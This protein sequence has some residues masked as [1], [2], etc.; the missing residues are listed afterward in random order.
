MAGQYDEAL[1]GAARRAAELRSP[2]ASYHVGVTLLLLGDDA[3]TERYLTEKAERSPNFTRLPLGL[4]LLELRRGQPRAAVER[5]RALAVEL[6]GNIEVL[7]TRAEIFMFAGTADASEI[8]Q[9][10]MARA[11]DGLVHNAPYPVK[12]LHAYYLHR[13]GRTAEAAKILDAILAANRT[14]LVAGADGST[15]FMQNAAVHALRGE[16]AAALDELER[17][18]A[19]GWRDGRTLAIDPFFASMRAEARFTQLLSRIEADV[20]AMRARRIIRRYPDDRHASAEEPGGARPRAALIDHRVMVAIPPCPTRAVN[21]SG[22]RAITY[23]TGNPGGSHLS[24]L[25][26]ELIG[27]E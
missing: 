23:T 6:P 21:R 1:T 26:V 25:L 4:A 3:Q 7:L 20:A 17:A 24:D 18:Y 16:T 12:L 9:S 10:L 13:A 14:S 22:A 19:A 27:L 2:A 5:V 8:V 15:M 11:A